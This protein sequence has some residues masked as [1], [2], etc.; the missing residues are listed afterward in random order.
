MEISN[1]AIFSQD[2]AVLL[3]PITFYISHYSFHIYNFSLSEGHRPFSLNS[4]ACG[5]LLLQCGDTSTGPDV[6]E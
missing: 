3:F 2:M 4:V 1:N 5:G 6:L